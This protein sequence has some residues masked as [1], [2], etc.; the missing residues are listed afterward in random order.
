MHVLPRTQM[1]NFFF[2]Q[3]SQLLFYFINS[4][5]IFNIN[6]LNILLTRKFK[7]SWDEI[8]IIFIMLC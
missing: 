4:T 7:K 1:Q 8:E 6:N 3:I 2:F 5:T